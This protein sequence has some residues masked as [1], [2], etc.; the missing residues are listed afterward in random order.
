MRVVIRYFDGCPSWRVTEDRIREALGDLGSPDVTIDRERVE[1][2]ERA[3]ELEFRGSPT[4]LIDG[5][6]P[7]LDETAPIGLS[8]RLY[9]TGAAAEGAPSL[10]ELR[11]VLQDRSH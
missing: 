8:C 5:V 7:F 1:T 4:V 3:R 6:D 2:V 9:R 11:R 10:A